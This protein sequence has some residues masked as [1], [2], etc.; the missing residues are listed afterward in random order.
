M[1]RHYD[2][3]SSIIQLL[4]GIWYD[5]CFCCQYVHSI[6]L[7][8]TIS[9]DLIFDSSFKVPL[10]LG[11]ILFNIKSHIIN[12]FWFLFT[13]TVCLSWGWELFSWPSLHCFRNLKNE[14]SMIKWKK[15]G[16]LFTLFYMNWNSISAPVVKAMTKWKFY[17]LS[18][19][20]SVY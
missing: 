17:N 9:W 6:T 5:N 11:H 10:L 1:T 8:T 12:I 15:F 3:T 19:V 20:Y 16:N 7:K 4:I 14:I 18:L 13:S 2:F